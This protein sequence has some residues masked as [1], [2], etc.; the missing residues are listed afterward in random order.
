MVK[1]L[2]VLGVAAGLAVS[3]WSGFYIGGNLGAASKGDLE[4]WQES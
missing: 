2:T 3:A 4:R 1:G